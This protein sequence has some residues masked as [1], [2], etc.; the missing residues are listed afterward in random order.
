RRAA[1]GRWRWWWRRGRRRRRWRRRRGRRRRW[2]WWRRGRRRWWR[3]RRRRA[4]GEGRRR[5]VPPLGQVAGRAARD[6]HRARGVAG[7]QQVLLNVLL[8]RGPPLVPGRAVGAV[9]DLGPV[10]D[11]LRR[12]ERPVDLRAAQGRHAG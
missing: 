11:V 7:A 6:P 12:A 9:L 8:Q 1:A 5:P 10:G 3:R 4:V 2:R